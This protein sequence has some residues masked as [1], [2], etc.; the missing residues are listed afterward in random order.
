MNA[1]RAMD[2]ED[3]Y[4]QAEITDRLDDLKQF[5]P[6]RYAISPIKSM[7]ALHYAGLRLMASGAERLV[8]AETIMV[9]LEEAAESE[10]AMSRPG[11]AGFVNGYPEVFYSASELKFAENAR[12]ELRQQGEDFTT[13]SP[14]RAEQAAMLR[15]A[16]VTLWLRFVGGKNPKLNRRALWLSACGMGDAAI[17]RKLGLPNARAVKNRRAECLDRIGDRL[18]REIKT[19]SEIFS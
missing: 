8:L 2:M 16:E 3:R 7:D 1:A 18:R 6:Q 12:E 17:S 19:L 5:Q 9:A 11:P 15:H 13:P 14:L 10:R 4:A